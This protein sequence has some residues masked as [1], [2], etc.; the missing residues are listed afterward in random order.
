[1]ESWTSAVPSGALSVPPCF[2]SNKP[3]ERSRKKNKTKREQSDKLFPP[4]KTTDGIT[5]G[6]PISPQPWIPSAAWLCLAPN[7]VAL[8]CM[9]K[10]SQRT[11]SLP[12]PILV[13][14]W[15]L[16]CVIMSLQEAG[17]EGNKIKRYEKLFFFVQSI[18]F[19][20]KGLLPATAFPLLVDQLA[21]GQ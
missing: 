16:Q 13:V 11:D 15:H 12:K 21:N 5:E 10:M 4:D 20:K 2:V 9:S 8:G 3:S 19:F 14:S 18:I 6:L 1:M 7:S 17:R